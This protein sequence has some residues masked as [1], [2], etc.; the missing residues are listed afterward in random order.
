MS[1]LNADF[2]ASMATEKLSSDSRYLSNTSSAGL[3][4]VRFLA[5]SK[6]LLV[7]PIVVIV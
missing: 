4:N 6:F 3:E 1:R 5:E 2:Y 7:F